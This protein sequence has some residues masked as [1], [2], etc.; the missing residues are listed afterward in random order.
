MQF[1]K[2]VADD[3][4]KKY[5]NDL[6]RVA[7]VFPNKRAGIFFDDYLMSQHESLPVWAPQ[8]LT[9][10]DLFDS[11]S[12][13]RKAD[14]IKAVCALYRIYREVQV[15]AGGKE[16]S[17][18]FF[19]GWGTQL[20]SDFSNIDRSMVDAAEM[21][22]TWSAVKD[23]ERLSEEDRTHLKPLVETLKSNSALKNDFE[24]LWSSLYQIYGALNESLAKDGEAYE[25]A[26][27]RRVIE[28]LKNGKIKLSDRF[29]RYAFVGFN[30]LVPAEWQLF[31]FIKNE[32]KSLYYWDY[33]QMYVGVGATLSFGK[34]LKENMQTFPNELPEDLFDNLEGRESAIEFVA[35][36]SDS[37]QTRFATDWLK[38]HI[39]K[40]EERRTAVVLCDETLLQ[41]VIHSLPDDVREVNITKGFPM[42]HTPAFAFVSH[43]FEQ[44]ETAQPETEQVSL[45]E[46]LASALQQQAQEEMKQ[47]G[48]QTWMGQLTAESYF[49]CFTTIN[50][51]LNFVKDGTLVVNRRMLLSLLR[52]ILATLSIPFHGEPASGLQVMGMLETRNLDFDELLMLSVNDGIVPKTVSD[53]SF[54]PYDLRKHYRIMTGDEQSEVYAYNFFRLLQRSRHVTLVYNES[55][56]GDKHCGEMSRFMLQ[57]LLQTKI[58]VHCFSLKEQ[59]AVIE[60]K[61]LGLDETKSRAIM[62]ERA[63]NLSASAL[64]EYIDC[65][66][67][68]FFSHLA[69]MKELPQLS[70]ILP[71]NTFG[72]IFHRAAECIYGDFRKRNPQALQVVIESAELKSLSENIVKLEAFIR[73][74]FDTVSAEDAKNNP[75]LA[76][77]KN[78][79]QLYRA[80]EHQLEADVIRDYL[81]RVLKYDAG[82]AS[83]EGLSII[84]TE[85]KMEGVLDEK[86]KINGK[87]DRVDCVGSKTRVVDY[88]TGGYNR[89]KMSAKDAESLFRNNDHNYVMQT[90]LYELLYQ[91]GT[92]QYAQPAIYFAQKISHENYDPETNLGDPKA[93]PLSEEEELERF[94]TELQ[95]FIG[96]MRTSPFLFQKNSNC[97]YCPYILLCGLKK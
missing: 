7:V 91:L 48:E 82:V 77:G 8:Y 10:N 92:G 11:L 16:L 87:I 49:Q 58:P 93:L 55:T 3:L 85:Q 51:V 71:N 20:L 63:L 83:A 60:E 68:Y 73:E 88:K 75:V 56:D 59:C 19:Y 95:N 66:M 61:D 35:A 9:I 38:K 33:D 5:G 31:D 47:N 69:K 94:R 50:R 30:M 18:D 80:E 86:T 29:D 26:R 22:S 15:Q 6:S 17:L 70:E 89:A 97:D 81:Q 13:L 57:I 25:G 21:F 44:A 74:A 65:P 37:G 84:C 39:T 62:E 64:E 1:L 42:T 2:Y 52:Q 90:L 36:T 32:G 78:G 14:D 79:E 28:G 27:Q 67:K 23:L 96:K 46:Q 40:E 24:Q 54:I 53:R 72:S 41:P 4:R 34:T 76:A 45:L 43:F 12:P